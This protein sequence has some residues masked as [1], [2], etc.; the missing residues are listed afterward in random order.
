MLNVSSGEFPSDVTPAPVDSN[1]GFI[2]VE[3]FFCH[4]QVLGLPVLTDFVPDPLLIH[5]YTIMPLPAAAPTATPKV[6]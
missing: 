3:V 4:D 6:P 2:A 1:R 5:A